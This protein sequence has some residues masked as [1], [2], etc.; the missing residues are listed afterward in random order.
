MTAEEARELTLSS[1]NFKRK[2]DDV[3]EAL[4]Y[5]YD[6][7]NASALNGEVTFS[8]GFRKCYTNANEY[9]GSRA[10]FNSTLLREIV[11]TILK[12]HGYKVWAGPNQDL[13]I[14]WCVAF[15]EYVKE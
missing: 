15:D 10:G 6:K 5:I 2:Q 1:D 8:T 7:I 12:D 9:G 14:R 3:E 4:N 13:S 11:T